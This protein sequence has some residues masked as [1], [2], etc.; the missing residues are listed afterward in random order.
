MKIILNLLVVLSWFF[1]KAQSDNKI[2][3]VEYDYSTILGNKTIPLKSVLKCSND[4]SIFKIFSKSN[5]N[6]EK[7][8]LDDETISVNLNRF[9]DYY[10]FNLNK[11]LLLFTENIENKVY[12]IKDNTSLMEWHLSEKKEDIKRINSFL[13]NKAILNFRGRNYI[14]WYSLG[15]PLPFGPWKFNG[16]PGLILEIYDTEN[17]FK[18]SATKIVYPSKEIVNFDIIDKV[19]TNQISLKDF[20]PKLENSIKTK[21]DIMLSRLPRG[22][23]VENITLTRNTIELIFEW[24]SKNSKKN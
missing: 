12:K 13:C 10:E 1:S 20:I 18:W 4:K 11:K 16:L 22:V 8:A 19:K 7:I 23:K 3:S 21:Q 15:I 17:I 5:S 14:A 6:D 24:E 2:I 9:D